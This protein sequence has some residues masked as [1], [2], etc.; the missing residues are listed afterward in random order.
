M[1]RLTL[2]IAVALFLASVPLAR[3]DDKEEK[4]PPT[5]KGQVA[6]F[7]LANVT[8]APTDE[9][10]PLFGSG[11][12]ISFKDLVAR[13]KKAGEDDS[14]KALVLFPE[15]GLGRAQIEE[16]R[17]VLALVKK[18]GKD[19]YVHADELSTAEY[20][21]AAAATRISMVPT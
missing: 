14:V 1:Q 15:G 21:L 7:R 5:G 16:V 6:V 10:F 19:I 2:A 4:K 20:V 9:D 11:R 13:M 12:S 18:A 3:A 17:Q 8:E